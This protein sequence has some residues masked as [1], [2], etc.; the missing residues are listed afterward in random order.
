[1]TTPAIGSPVL[2]RLHYGKRWQPATV[3]A[4]AGA[5]VLYLTVVGGRHY[6]WVPPENWRPITEA[7][8]LAVARKEEG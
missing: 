5:G 3:K 8:R 4:H 7:P 1:M 2:A 6:H